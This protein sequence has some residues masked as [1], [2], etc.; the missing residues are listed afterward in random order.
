[1]ARM[2][3]GGKMLYVDMVDI[4][5]PGIFL[6]LAGFQALFGQSIFMMR[7]LTALWIA[8]TAFLIHKSAIILF[9]DKRTAIAG[10]IIYIFFISTWTFYGLSLTPEIYFNLFTILSFFILLKFRT[11]PA[12]F[13]AGLIAGAG[14]IVKYLVISDFIAI[15][16]FVIYLLSQND[17]KLRPARALIYMILAGLGFL[18]PFILFNLVYLY[19]GHFDELLNIVYLAPSRYPSPFEPWKMLKFILSFHL[20]FLPVFFFY[21]Y[22]LADNKFNDPDIRALKWFFILWPL[23]SLI[24]VVAAGKTF[25]HYTIQL[26]LPLSLMAGSFFHQNRKLPLSLKNPFGLK[27]WTIMLGLLILALSLI[28]I[29][30]A[31]KNDTAGEIATYLK[32]RLQHE[33]VIYAGNYHHILYFL[34][35]KDSP[36]KYI[37]RSLL[38]NHKHIKALNIDTEKEFDEIIGK[39]PAYIVVENE[40]PNEKIGQFIAESYS[41]DTAFD[42]RIFLFKFKENKKW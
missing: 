27:P 41:L 11:A 12:F 21:Y 39:R 23:L 40:Y 10:G 13:T 18:I 33:D 3:L 36:T 19:N 1:M 4:K 37:H 28:K 38:L 26:M 30:Y 31:M 15:V 22:S 25:G 34:L 6:I 42:N 7:L 14:F 35:K 29:E 2:L 9:R 20:L 5:P 24:A 16:V 8:L 32:P 17:K